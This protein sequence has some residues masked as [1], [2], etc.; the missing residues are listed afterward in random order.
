MVRWN[1]NFFLILLALIAV[2][3]VYRFRLAARE[4]LARS[5]LV[6]KFQPVPISKPRIDI[7]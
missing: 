7:R 3:C 6:L 1:V 2:A 4:R 5:P